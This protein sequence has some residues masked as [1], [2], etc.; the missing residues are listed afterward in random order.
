VPTVVSDAARWPRALQAY[1]NARRTLVD[2]L[3]IEPGSRLRD[4]E[5]AILE[6]SPALA[7]YRG[8]AEP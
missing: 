2:D 7:V 5:R 6:Q 3:G 8:V 1:Q 4:L